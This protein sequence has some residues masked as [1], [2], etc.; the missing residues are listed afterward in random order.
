MAFLQE[1][2][3]KKQ[4]STGGKQINPEEGSDKKSSV[5]SQICR[6]FYGN[7]V[8]FFKK[9]D[10]IIYR[11][12][13]QKDVI[14]ALSQVTEELVNR[15]FVVG[16]KQLKKALNNGSAKKVFLACN[17]DPAI[18]EPIAALCQLKSVDFAWVR[19]MADL[20]HACGIEVGAAAAAVVA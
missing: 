6:I 12:D 10:I 14:M 4:K 18:T 19:S 9:K 13:T 11:M 16:I 2:T 7:F 8:D 15:K 17:A 3:I 5:I 1:S 20:G